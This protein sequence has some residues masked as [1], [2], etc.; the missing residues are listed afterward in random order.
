M[1]KPLNKKPQ[2]L[3]KPFFELAEKPC[4]V[5]AVRHEAQTLVAQIEDQEFLVMINVWYG[6]LSRVNVVSKTMQKTSVELPTAVLRMNN[7]TDYVT[8]YHANGYERA[9]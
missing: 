6:V 3:E 4:F 7:V 1:S 8:D 2:E 5:P 9:L